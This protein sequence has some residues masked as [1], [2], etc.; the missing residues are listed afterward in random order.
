VLEDTWF[1]KI[2][3]DTTKMPSR[4]RIIEWISKSWSEVSKET[5]VNS[6]KI[7]DD[8]RKEIITASRV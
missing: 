2:G 6:W 7:D 1:E 8:F 5:V 3:G 4:D